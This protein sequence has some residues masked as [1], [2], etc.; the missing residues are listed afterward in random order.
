MLLGKKLPKFL[1]FDKGAFP[2][3]G[4]RATIHQGQVYKSNGRKTTF[5]PSYRLIT[6]MSEASVHTNISGGASDRRFSKYY[7]NDFKNWQSGKYKKIRL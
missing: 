3:P 5:A 7:A 6:D 1:G 4:G 2:M